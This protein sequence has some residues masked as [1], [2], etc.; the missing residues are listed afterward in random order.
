MVQVR[1]KASGL[2][3]P[4]GSQEKLAKP[5]TDLTVTI[6]AIDPENGY[7]EETGEPVASENDMVKVQYPDGTVKNHQVKTMVDLLERVKNQ[8]TS[9]YEISSFEFGELPELK[10]GSVI[11]IKGVK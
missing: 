7:V 11:T 10:A 1:S 8:I 4:P 6:L 2:V 9:K 5:D 3:L